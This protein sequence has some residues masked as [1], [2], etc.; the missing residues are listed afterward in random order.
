MEREPLG[1]VPAAMPRQGVR[2]RFRTTRIAMQ[3]D[4]VVFTPS[5][6]RGRFAAGDGFPLS[7]AAVRLPERVGDADPAHGERRRRVR[8]P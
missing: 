3:D 8:R 5:G 2:P 1:I 7:G 4:L 6:K